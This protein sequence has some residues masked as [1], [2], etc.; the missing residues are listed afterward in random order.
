MGGGLGKHRVSRT[1]VQTAGKEQVCV[2]RVGLGGVEDSGLC[3]FLLLPLRP[4][5]LQLHKNL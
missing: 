4:W 3:A 5:S 1:F 2:A